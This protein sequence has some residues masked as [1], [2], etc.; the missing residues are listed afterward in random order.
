MRRF[1]QMKIL[2]ALISVEFVIISML[3][4]RLK[5][6]QQSKASQVVELLSRVDHSLNTT[7]SSIQNT[8]QRLGEVIDILD[9]EMRI[10]NEELSKMSNDDD[11]DTF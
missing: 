2:L 1:K 6:K 11:Q 5:N 4:F 10:M 9:G 3:W 7:V 8:N